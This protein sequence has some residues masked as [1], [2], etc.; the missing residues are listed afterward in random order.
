MSKIGFSV[1]NSY[2]M[3][4]LYGKLTEQV[5]RIVRERTKEEVKEALS[6]DEKMEKFATEVYSRLSLDVKSK[7]SIDVFIK[8]VLEKKESIMKVGRNLKKLK[9]KK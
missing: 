5:S 7:I 4:R 1:A 9:G 6:S 2:S 8:M 3:I